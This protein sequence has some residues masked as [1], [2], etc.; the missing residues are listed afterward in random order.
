M[1]WMNEWNYWNNK[2]DSFFPF[3][4]YGK[5]ILDTH[6]YDFKKTVKEEEQ[7]WDASRWP[8]VKEIAS[9]VPVFIGEYTL[10]L[11]RDIP[12]DKLQPWAQY[13]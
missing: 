7:S 11:G 13:V 1:E 4:T 3:S 5:V 12:T 9:Q 6:I 10:A 8:K 2:W